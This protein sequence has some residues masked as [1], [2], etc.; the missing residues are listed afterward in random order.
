MNQTKATAASAEDV[1]KRQDYDNNKLAEE[2]ILQD[3]SFSNLY[4]YVVC[5]DKWCQTHRNFRSVI[6][7]SECKE[8]LR[9]FLRCV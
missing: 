4:D 6:S 5:S 9:L 7:F 1:Y 8:V 3:E 2:K